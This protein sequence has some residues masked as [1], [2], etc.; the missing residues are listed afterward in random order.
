MFDHFA[1]CYTLAHPL[2]GT[3]ISASTY[4]YCMACLETHSLPTIE[5]VLLPQYEQGN[6]RKSGLVCHVESRQ[7]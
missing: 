5:T 7:Y 6:M 3:P 1:S 4:M 2:G